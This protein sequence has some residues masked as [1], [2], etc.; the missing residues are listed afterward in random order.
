MERGT[1]GCL[2]AQPWRVADRP[3]ENGSHTLAKPRA[4]AVPFQGEPTQSYLLISFW[5]GR[6]YRVR[7]APRGLR[8][9][10]CQV[11]TPR[12]CTCMMQ[13]S[14]DAQELVAQEWLDQLF[15]PG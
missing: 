8:R 1:H 12:P 15:G 10:L 9:S 14:I 6:R 5:D 7:L 11:A 2:Y 13:T 3:A 4:P